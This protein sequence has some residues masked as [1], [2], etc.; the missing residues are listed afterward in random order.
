MQTKLAREALDSFKN[1]TKT[2]KEVSEGSHPSRG[3]VSRFQVSNPNP[4]LA[5]SRAN[6]TSSKKGEM[7]HPKR[8]LKSP[9]RSRKRAWSDD[10]RLAAM[11]KEGSQ[12]NTGAYVDGSFSPSNQ[13]GGGYGTTNL[14][15]ETSVPETPALPDGSESPDVEIADVKVSADKWRVLQKMGTLLD[16]EQP[17]QVQQP[18][19]QN[20]PTGMG[21]AAPAPV[22][23]QAPAPARA[24]AQL[25]TPMT[26]QAPMDDTAEELELQQLLYNMKQQNP[27]FYQEQAANPELPPTAAQPFTE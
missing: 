8:G 24:P 2:R 12:S 13:V 16:P 27:Q 4:V 10:E 21:S 25:P 6:V 7:T 3:E 17:E 18:P 23:T 5:Q 26:A 14:S 11:E 9:P 22:T 20:I 1:H 19:I 15:E